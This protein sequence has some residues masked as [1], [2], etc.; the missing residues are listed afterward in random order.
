MRTTP[1]PKFYVNVV[2]APFEDK[3]I[4]VSVGKAGT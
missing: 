2:H 3:R 4:Q 1:L